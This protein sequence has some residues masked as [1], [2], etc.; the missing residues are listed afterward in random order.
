MLSPFL[1]KPSNVIKRRGFKIE[2]SA[3]FNMDVTRLLNI[4]G[5]TTTTRP[6]KIPISQTQVVA[7]VSFGVRLAVTITF[8]TVYGLLFFFIMVQLWLKLYYRHKRLSYQS[9]FLFICLLW[10]AV[11]TTLFSFYFHD[12]RKANSLSSFPRWLMYAFPSW[13]QFLTLTLLTLYLA[14]VRP[15]LLVVQRNKNYDFILKVGSFL[16]ANFL[17]GSFLSC[18]FPARNL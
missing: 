10:A 17:L 12:S 16:L 14:Q 5:A 15:L 9:I 6:T 13:L 18:N 8:T 4:I 11:R 1:E 2:L 3:V 7:P